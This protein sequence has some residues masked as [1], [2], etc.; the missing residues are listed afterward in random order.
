MQSE[1]PVE[2]KFVVASERRSSGDENQ[3]S[4][5]QRVFEHKGKVMTQ[6]DMHA[7]G[8]VKKMEVPKH[9]QETMPEVSRPGAPVGPLKISQFQPPLEKDVKLCYWNRAY[10]NVKEDAETAGA[11][12]R[13]LDQKPHQLSVPEQNGLRH[14]I[15]SGYYANPDPYQI[16]N[17]ET[18]NVHGRTV[19][20]VESSYKSNDPDQPN[21]RSVSMFV[22]SDGTGR[23]TEQIYFVAP[24]SKFKEYAP[25]ALQSMESVKWRRP[26]RSPF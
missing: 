1:A 20:M 10:G 17:A 26:E 7:D 13:V 15:A 11:L 24:E 4:L 12:Q 5:F 2:S 9:W 25:H 18:K 8:S 3:E 23:Y 22:N 21:K 6:G 14:L 19:L 16:V